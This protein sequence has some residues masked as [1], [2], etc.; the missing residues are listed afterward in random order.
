MIENGYDNVKTV[1]GGGEA[2]EKIFDHY[3]NGKLIRPS[4][5][6]PLRRPGR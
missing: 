4:R 5:G 3:K 1:S 2:M 6:I